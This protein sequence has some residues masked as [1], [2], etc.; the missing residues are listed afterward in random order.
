MCSFYVSVYNMTS[1]DTFLFADLLNPSPVAETKAHLESP[2][3][4]VHSE[5]NMTEEEERELAELLD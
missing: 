3:T 2:P 5:F 1:Q 4:K